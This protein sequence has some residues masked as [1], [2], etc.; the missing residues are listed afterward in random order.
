MIGLGDG[1]SEKDADPDNREHWGLNFLGKALMRARERIWREQWR[2]GMGGEEESSPSEGE[3]VLADPLA[4]KAR[5]LEKKIRDIEKLER[6]QAASEKLESNQ[7]QQIEGK[8]ALQAELKTL[9]EEIA[10][11]GA[12]V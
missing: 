4:K 11:A 1:Y 5:K 3:S 6:R 8:E 10:S 9:Q 2:K 12:T 7:L